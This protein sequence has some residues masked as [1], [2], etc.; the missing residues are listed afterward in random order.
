VPQTNILTGEPVAPTAPG[1]PQAPGTFSQTPQGPDVAATAAT[2]AAEEGSKI[3]AGAR[4]KDLTDDMNAMDSSQT[5]LRD[6]G[7]LRQAA[8]ALPNDTPMDQAQ[9]AFMNRMFGETGITFTAGQSAREAF[10][11]VAKQMIGPSRR[12][13]GVT[14]VAG[15]ELNLFD[16]MLPNAF[17]DRA[18]LTKALDT[19]ETKARLGLQTGKLALG[20]VAK[21]A[22]GT[23]SP[24]DYTDYRRAKE[25]LNAPPTET[26]PPGSTPPPSATELPGS[27]AAPQLPQ[28]YRIENGQR[29]P[30]PSSGG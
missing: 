10:T 1:T 21:S 3:A 26:M 2:T 9:S 25:A 28:R 11:S 7:L 23:I 27:H 8:N 12:D 29:I 19:I 13:V 24:Q 17:Q 15:P 14:R 30:I 18:S 6:I 20:V 22:D 5:L 4:V 16:Q